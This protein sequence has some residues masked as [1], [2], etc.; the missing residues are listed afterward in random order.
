M[1]L[2][3]ASSPRAPRASMMRLTHSS[4][5][6]LRG[7]SPLVTAA[8]KAITSAT[9]LTVSWNCRQAGATHQEASVQCGDCQL[10]LQAGRGKHIKGLLSNE[11]DCQL[12]LR[13]RQEKTIKRLLTLQQQALRSWQHS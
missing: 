1:L 5:M 6:T 11:V 12:G 13:G 9:K 8:T 4:W 7:V 2:Q 10:E 3:A